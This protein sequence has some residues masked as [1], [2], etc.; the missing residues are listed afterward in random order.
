M[1]GGY[2]FTQKLTF[3][4]Y[5]LPPAFTRVSLIHLSTSPI[6][7]DSF[8]YYKIYITVVAVGAVDKWISAGIWNLN[9]FEYHLDQPV[10]AF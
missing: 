8:F 9:Y 6:Y 1:P 7:Y 4:S 10:E 3:A 2:Q 5:W